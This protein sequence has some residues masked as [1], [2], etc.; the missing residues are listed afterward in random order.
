MTA[1]C[2]YVRNSTACEA[3]ATV[4][5]LP[6]GA[7]LALDLIPV[8]VACALAVVQDVVA[9]AFCVPS[10][11]TVFAS[12]VFPVETYCTLAVPSAVS[13]HC[14]RILNSVTTRTGVAVVVLTG[15]ADGALV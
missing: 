15:R 8:V 6:V 1:S 7:D 2:L 10:I 5:E 11:I 3:G 9:S 14:L 12:I 13:P 4:I